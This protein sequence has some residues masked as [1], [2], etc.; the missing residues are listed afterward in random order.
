MKCLCYASCPVK[1]PSWDDRLARDVDTTA[2]HCAVDAQ[3]CSR[4]DAMCGGDCRPNLSWDASKPGRMISE[5][6]LRQQTSSCLTDRE[7]SWV[8]DMAATAALLSASTLT[9]L[10]HSSTSISE[11]VDLDLIEQI[12]DRAPRQATSFPLVYRAY[13]EVLEEK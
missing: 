13:G 7:A 9:S 11:S 1:S 3:L 4:W 8:A 6:Q 10:G 2:C 12:I 5:S